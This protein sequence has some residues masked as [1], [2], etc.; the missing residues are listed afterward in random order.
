MERCP[1]KCENTDTVEENSRRLRIS[2]NRCDKGF[3]QKVLWTE[4][5]PFLFNLFRTETLNF[6]FGMCTTATLSQPFFSQ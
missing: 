4:V 1:V 2:H 3:T 6:I 5:Q